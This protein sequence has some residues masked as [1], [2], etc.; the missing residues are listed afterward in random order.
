MIY[1]INSATNIIKYYKK[2]MNFI[3][4]FDNKLKIKKRNFERKILTNKIMNQFFFKKNP[5]RQKKLMIESCLSDRKREEGEKQVINFSS[6]FKKKTKTPKFK[7]LVNTKLVQSLLKNCND[8]AKN[9]IKSEIVNEQMGENYLDDDD[10]IFV[11]KRKV[12]KIQF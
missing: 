5:E 11:N 2:D 1:V 6:Y 8:E 7:S 3:N 9:M 4:K 10:E 12:I